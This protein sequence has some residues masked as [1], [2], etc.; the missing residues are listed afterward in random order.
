[1]LVN[2]GSSLSSTTK[3]I[4]EIFLMSGFYLVGQY[5][6]RDVHFYSIGSTKRL[7]EFLQE[8]FGRGEEIIVTKITKN[9]GWERVEPYEEFVSFVEDNDLFRKVSK[10]D[11]ITNVKKAMIAFER[12]KKKLGRLPP[13]TRDKGEVFAC[14]ECRVIFKDLKKCD[15]D[16]CKCHHF[17]D[18]E[19]FA[20]VTFL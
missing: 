8:E 7:L 1:M 10:N 16:E 12:M 14:G 9:E 11:G 4:Q 6:D 13:G 15:K 20:K 5:G 3:S 17:C 18:C 2:L 19:A